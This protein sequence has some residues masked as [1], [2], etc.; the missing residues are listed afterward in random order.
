MLRRDLASALIVSSAAAVMLSD[1]SH[2]QACTAPCYA[3]TSAEM[4]AGVTI[5]NSSYMPGNVLRYG[6]NTT[7]GTTNTRKRSC[8][9]MRTKM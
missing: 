4:T 2:A 3:A 5:V 6:T 7:P 1:K 8:S 9:R